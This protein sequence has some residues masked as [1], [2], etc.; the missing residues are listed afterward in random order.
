M[1]TWVIQISI[2]SII[3]IFLVHHLLMFFKT[4]LT[5][6][7]IKDMVKRPQQRYD[8]L[9]RELRNQVAENANACKAG[10]SINFVVVENKLKFEYSKNNALK[11][12]LKTNDDIKA[13]AINIE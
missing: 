3:F 4:T 11:A 7:K 12:G 1:L 5:V 6:P 8:T 9:F 13:L 2:I 10:S